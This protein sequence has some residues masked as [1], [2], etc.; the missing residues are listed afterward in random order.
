MARE[1]LKGIKNYST[2][3]YVVFE[4][5]MLT[6]NGKEIPVEIMGKTLLNKMGLPV[7]LQGSTRNITE[8]R[9]ANIALQKSE[10]HLRNIFENSTN[11]Y[12]SHDTDHKLNYVSPQVINILGYTQEEALSKWTDFVSDNPLNEIGFQNTINAI[13]T[14]QRQPIYEL[15]LVRKDKIKIIVE[16]RES[17]VLK[18]GKVIGIVG[19]LNDITERKQIEKLLTESEEK[20]RGIYEQSPIAIEI[21]DKN[22][23]LVDVNQTTLDMFGVDNKKHVLGFDLWADPNL[24]SEEILSLKNGKPI[25]LS[26]DFDFE[27]VKK[28]NLYPT[29]H[30]GIIYMDMYAIPLMEENDIT[31]YL[32]QIVEITERKIAKDNLLQSETRFRSLFENSPFGIVICELINDEKGQAIDFIHLQ[33]NKSTSMQTGFNLM[34]LV[35]K[36]ASELVPNDI[37]KSLV[38][39]YESVIKTGKSINFIEYYE[40][41]DKSLEVTAFHLADNL[42]ILNLIDISA[43]KKAE[44]R[45][46]ESEEKFRK[47]F[48]RIPLPLSLADADGNITLSNN[49][50]YE[51]FG[52]TKN[53]VP[54]LKEY[55]LK[56]YPDKEYREWVKKNWESAVQKA[57]IN[58]SDIKSDEYIFT[59]KDGSTRNI[60]ISGIT[61]DDGVLATFIDITERKE[62]EKSLVASEEKFKSLMHQ[63]P[64]IVELYDIDGLQ[65]EV[66]KAYEELWGF[67]ASITVNIF[68]ILKSK[69]VV[70]T[71]LIEYVNRAY[72]GETVKVPEYEF[73][74]TGDTE[75]KGFGRTRYL[76]TSIYPIKNSKNE[77]LNIV[78]VHQDVTLR[79][80][81]EKELLVAKKQ[82]EE[83]DRLKTAFLANMSHEIRTPMNGVI[84]MTDLLAKTQLSDE[85]FDYVDTIRVSGESL[86]RVINDILDYSKAESGKIDLEIL[87]TSLS[88]MLSPICDLMKRTTTNAATV[89]HTCPR[90]TIC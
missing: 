21:F 35:N 81:K 4:A 46:L 45:L 56:A 60:I 41:Y 19:S 36:K 3:N 48:D 38:N 58:G 62:S 72:A 71:G 61:I 85:Q 63:S 8:R 64:F 7:G 79:K 40:I 44:K 37:L 6:K 16:V 5:I 75:S 39:K 66:N 74:P 43:R 20:F 68:N 83:S 15:E 33:G 53:D 28:H 77:V 10:E 14:G 2:Y 22:G 27:V 24:S 65:I 84:G 50:Y 52:Y 59:C 87:E 89:S 55:W 76:N 29:K 86:L 9:Q 11:M 82:A 42:F 18:D 25:L 67:P 26:I 32:V 88:D 23:K 69:E 73:D 34:D 78:V 31:G 30:S 49:R 51:V 13:K 17:P 1:A 80:E 57:A 12:Y 54:T 47:L 90:R 70:E